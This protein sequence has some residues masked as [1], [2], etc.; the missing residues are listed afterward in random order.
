MNRIFKIARIGTKDVTVEEAPD[1]RSACWA[2]GWDPEWCEVVDI[3]DTVI[4]LE[5]VA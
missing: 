2:A 4:E 5:V 1:G 3:T